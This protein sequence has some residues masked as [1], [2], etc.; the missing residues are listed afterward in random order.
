MGTGSRPIFHLVCRRFYV[1]GFSGFTGE[2]EM[3]W[4]KTAILRFAR[5]SDLPFF[6]YFFPIPSFTSVFSWSESNCSDVY[7]ESPL[8]YLRR[9]L[10][11][12]VCDFSTRTVKRGCRR[13]YILVSPRFMLR[14]GTSPYL[15]QSSKDLESGVRRIFYRSSIYR[16][17]FTWR[18]PPR[19]GRH[20]LVGGRNW[21]VYCQPRRR[22]I[23]LEDFI[24]RSLF[25]FS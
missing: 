19:E 1:E 2:R 21:K 17:L 10:A 7:E 23:C 24:C 18:N 22:E 12:R 16:N 15:W 4:I 5:G 14:S 6:P 8:I 3:R 20:S 9:V 13:T 25:S 11:T